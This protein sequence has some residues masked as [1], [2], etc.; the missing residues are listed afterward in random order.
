MS[1]TL[2]PFAGGE[3][4]FLYI[5]ATDSWGLISLATV[6]FRAIA[7]THER[8][9]LVVDDTRLA[10]DQFTAGSPVPRVYGNLP[11]PAAAE[12]DTFL[13]AVGGFPWRGPQGVA[14]D[15]PL[16]KP[17]LFAGYSFDTLGTR[18]GFEV[19]SAGVPLGLLGR[20]RRVV[21]LTDVTGAITTYGPDS[22][23][24]PLSTLRWMSTP[25]R[26]STLAAYFHSGG[27]VWLAGGTGL[28]CATLPYNATGNQAN[29][30]TYGPGH[31]VFSYTHG[32]LAP[33][34][35]AWDA[36]HWRSEFV[37]SKPITLPRRS[38]RALGG[39]SH[40]GWQF[41][42]PVA[43]P[44]YARLPANLRRRAL[45]LGDSLPPT[46]TGYPTAYYSTAI[47]PAVEYL[48]QENFIL[49]DIAADAGVVDR[50]AVLDTLYELQGGALA[51]QY[52]GSRPVAMTYY[53][54]VESPRFVQT[55]FDLWTWSR[56]DVQGLVDFVLGEIWGMNRTMP[57]PVPRAAASPA[58]PPRPVRRAQPGRPG[59]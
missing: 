43:A 5:E 54:G 14:G 48:T 53:H 58:T 13:F 3:E 24:D 16:S 56:Q 19:A 10:P 29:D 59:R 41:S 55:G 26:T 50:V 39:W 38:N 28:T 17:G 15:L 46:R 22:P 4:H 57:R 11:W 37:A 45:A 49:E 27:E 2:G 12:L 18:Q 33:G 47:N 23:V 51:T 52:T 44:D 40:P 31:T 34:R 8:D 1:V 32:E 30:G 35:L 42:R 6:H 7:L 36:A 21:W 25:G 20:Y 9:L